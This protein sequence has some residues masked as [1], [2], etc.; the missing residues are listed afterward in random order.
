MSVIGVIVLHVFIPFVT[1]FIGDNIICRNDF[2][3]STFILTCGWILSIL[4]AMNVYMKVTKNILVYIVSILFLIFDAIMISI[5]DSQKYVFDICV[6]NFIYL[7]WI[8][9]WN[10]FENSWENIP[11]FYKRNRVDIFRVFHRSF[12]WLI[13]ASNIWFC[14]RYISNESGLTSQLQHIFHINDWNND[15]DNSIYSRI[16]NMVSTHYAHEKRRLFFTV[17][18]TY[19]FPVLTLCTCFIYL[20]DKYLVQTICR[21]TMRL[22][23]IEIH[24]SSDVYLRNTANEYA[25]ECDYDVLILSTDNDKDFI[26]NNSIVSCLEEKDYKVCFPESDL[27]AGGSVI[28]IYQKVINS[29]KIIIVVYSKAF[30]EDCFMHQIVLE[31]MITSLSEDSKNCDKSIFFIIKDECN[32][33]NFL[34]KYEFL[35]TRQMFSKRNHIRRQLYAWMEGKVPRSKSVCLDLIIRLISIICYLSSVIS[36]IA[37]MAIIICFSIELKQ[38]INSKKNYNTYYY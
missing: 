23:G 24:S 13:L 10:F 29:S 18:G 26:T 22:S 31:G 36:I 33:P 16:V 7:L 25:L 27:N 30:L 38:V 11:T 12:I 17:C 9:F 6:I 21:Y 19:F 28:D 8:K 32:I 1:Y 14:I 15:A 5:I 20:L 35:D 4:L 37:V 3:M 2:H 34:G